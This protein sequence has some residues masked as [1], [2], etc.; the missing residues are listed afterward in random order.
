MKEM[1]SGGMD[2]ARFL[3]DDIYTIDKMNEGLK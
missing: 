1:G 3:P 2:Y